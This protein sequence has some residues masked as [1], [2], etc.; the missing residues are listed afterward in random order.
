[1]IVCIGFEKERMNEKKSFVRSFFGSCKNMV[2]ILKKISKN[3]LTFRNEDA[4]LR[5]VAEENKENQQS[6]P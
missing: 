5:Y 6:G 4:I 2:K 1:M 3:L